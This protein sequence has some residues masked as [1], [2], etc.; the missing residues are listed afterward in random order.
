MGALVDQGWSLSLAWESETLGRTLPASSVC[1]VVCAN[2]S[3]SLA[4]DSLQEKKERTALW[5][6]KTEP[7]GCFVNVSNV[8]L[9]GT[10]DQ[11]CLMSRGQLLPGWG[12]GVGLELLDPLIFQ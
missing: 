5:A 7:P 3:P 11:R 10:M 6:W 9:W 1:H 2:V 4:P 8:G 12:P